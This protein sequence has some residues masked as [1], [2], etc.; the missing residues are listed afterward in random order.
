MEDFAL[1]DDAI[2]PASW[3]VE[4]NQP[5]RLRADLK[6][7]LRASIMAALQPTRIPWKVNQNWREFARHA[8]GNRG[9][10]EKT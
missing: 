10:P 3:I 4:H 8:L 1:K 6:G 2:R 9:S 7:D 5:M